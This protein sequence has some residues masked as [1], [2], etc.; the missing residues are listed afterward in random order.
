MTQEHG[1][2]GCPNNHTDHGQPD[3]THSF[4]CVSTISY[5]QH[6]THGHKQGVGV[7]DVPGRI[8][9]TVQKGKEF[10]MIN[11]PNYFI[12]IACMHLALMIMRELYRAKEG[13]VMVLCVSVASLL[14]AD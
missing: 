5:T 12:V 2:A 13:D 8:L 9:Q 7:L 6:M 10:P 3:V 11:I 14:P 1:V 4:W